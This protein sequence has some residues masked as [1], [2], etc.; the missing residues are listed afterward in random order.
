MGK[1]SKPEI[2]AFVL[3]PF[4]KPLR[5]A[6]G[7]ILP[8]YR[9]LLRFHP[10]HIADIVQHDSSYLGGLMF[11]RIEPEVAGGVGPNSELHRENG[12][13]IVTRLNYEFDGW[14]GDGLLETTA[15]YI[16]TDDG[17]RLG[18]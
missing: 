16:V 7:H 6:F 11:F 5:N 14:L 12:K 4:R 8:I 10:C 17:Q 18:K 9:R 2:A 13:L 1:L 15:C 3:P